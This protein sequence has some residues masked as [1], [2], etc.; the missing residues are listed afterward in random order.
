MH[1][2]RMLAD[3]SLHLACFRDGVFILILA[4]VR[5]PGIFMIDIL[6]SVLM[7]SIEQRLANGP[8]VY[9]ICT[10]LVRA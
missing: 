5:L 8:R 9:C 3:A 1:R 4:F 6:F 7:E 10:N 2:L